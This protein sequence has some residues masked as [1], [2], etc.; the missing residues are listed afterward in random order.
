[1]NI[2]RLVD[3]LIDRNY[4]EIIALGVPKSELLRKHAYALDGMA[5]CKLPVAMKDG[6]VAALTMLCLYAKVEISPRNCEI[7]LKRLSKRGEAKAALNM[8]GC[9]L[10]QIGLRSGLSLQPLL[11]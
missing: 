1:M 3:M 10:R 8:E 2:K 11:Q 4:T 5:S 6:N 7:V 9:L